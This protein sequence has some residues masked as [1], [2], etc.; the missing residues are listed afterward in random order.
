[1]TT[2]LEARVALVSLPGL[3]PARAGWLLRAAP[4]IE[5]VGHLRA[6]RLPPEIGPAPTGVTAQLV[7]RWTA[8]LRAI[9]TS[10]SAA[11]LAGAGISLVDPGH[12]HWPFGDDPDPPA[13]LFARGQTRLASEGPIVAVVGTRRCTALGRRVAFDL[14][15]ELAEAGVTVASGLATGIDS[16]AHA[17]VLAALGLAVGVVATG[18][19]VVYPRA[20][21][22]LWSRV[23]GEG[24]LLSEAPPGTRPE[25]WRF[26]AR[27]RLIAGLAGVVVVVESHAE[28]GSLLT[29][30]EAAD[31][32]RPVMAVPGSITSPASAGSNRLLRDGCS[33]V[34][35]TDDVLGALGLDPRAVRRAE[36]GI[37]RPA[38]R[39]E[40]PADRG[41]GPR[42]A[43]MSPLA[44]A[45]LA[46]VAAGSCHIDELVGASRATIPELLAE[47]GR[48]QSQG[49]LDVDGSTVSVPEKPR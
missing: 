36:V 21:R 20:N 41:R 13:V 23:G 8:A 39:G 45:V 1:V 40:V 24:L 19:D 37:A 22:E 9:D 5:V 26:P 31:R 48:L 28:G 25:R 30:A 47:I 4:A 16:A 10:G 43:P 46:E 6:G 14:G 33:P 18:L 11:E 38:G 3:G 27:N 32:G 34:C 12:E 7:R 15:A 42:L 2:E 17:G 44:M 49:L 29:A 35:S